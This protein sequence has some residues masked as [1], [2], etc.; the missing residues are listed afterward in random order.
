MVLVYIWY[1]LSPIL[2]LKY[3]TINHGGQ[4]KY[5]NKHHM[6]SNSGRIFVLKGDRRLV[7]KATKVLLNHTT[8][9]T[10][11][12]GCSNK[13][14][15]TGALSW[16]QQ[17]WKMTKWGKDGEEQ[18]HKLYNPGLFG[19]VLTDLMLCNNTPILVWVLSIVCPTYDTECGRYVKNRDW[20][21]EKKRYLCTQ[22]NW[23]IRRRVN[24]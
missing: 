9:V 3:T 8:R 13:I 21:K 16:Y 1:F 5:N 18:Q 6:K 10:T 15:Y 20:R 4:S 7:N 11:F 17:E 19:S 24:V 12:I 22:Y 14:I 2:K 23:K